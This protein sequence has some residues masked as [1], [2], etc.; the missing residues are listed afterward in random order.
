MY[1]HVLK[2]HVANTHTDTLAQDKSTNPALNV[3]YTVFIAEAR[4]CGM[5]SFSSDS[6]P[7]AANPV[8]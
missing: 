7:T 5:S 6:P 4:G 2:L 3:N 1:G 8:S